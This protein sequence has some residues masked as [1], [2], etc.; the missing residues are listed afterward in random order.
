[1]YAKIG[2]FYSFQMTVCC[3]GWIQPGQ[4]SSK[5]NNNYHLLYTTFAPPD[6]GLRYARNMQRLKKYFENNLCIKQVFLYTIVSR[7][8]VNKTQKMEN[9]CSNYSECMDVLKDYQ[10]TLR[11]LM[12][13]IYMEHPFLMLLDHTQRR[14]TVGRTPLDE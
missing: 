14:S 12:S 8:T 6:D 13:Y 4:N 10:L 1:M 5:K 3:P 11:R 9:L 2:T 7:C